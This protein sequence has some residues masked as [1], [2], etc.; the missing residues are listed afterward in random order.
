MYDLLLSADMMVDDPDA[1]AE[2]L[3]K[4]VGLLRNPSWRQAFPNHPYVA[5]FLRTHKSLAVA[6]TRIEPQ[7]HKDAPNHG[8]PVFPVYLQSL[9]EFQGAARPIKTHA[10]VLITRRLEQLLERLHRHRVPF[11]VAPLTTE[12]PFERLW[13]GVTPE[14]PTYDPAA[15]GGLCIEVMGFAPLQ[16]PDSVWEA[17]EPLD[18]PPGSLVRVVRREYLVRDLDVTLAALATNLDLEPEGAVES[19]SGLG[20]RRARIGF[21]VPHSATLDLIE[22]TRWN[23]EPG[24]YVHS[25][26]PGPY[27]IQISVNGLDAKADQLRTANVEFDVVEADESAPRRLRINPN[28]L[29]GVLIEFVAH[30]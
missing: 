22:A 6:P 14:R 21:N 4:K 3:E 7:G 8:D 10:T 19:F 11:R 25:W 18:Q 9:V 1:M 17:P 23:S 27:R 30:G 28:E 5:W 24:R 16:I 2:L 29:A 15:D 13:I 20:F 26:G 12:M